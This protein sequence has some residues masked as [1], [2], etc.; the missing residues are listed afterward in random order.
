MQ[1][2]TKLYL[3]AFANTLV[4]A[5]GIITSVV[6]VYVLSHTLTINEFGMWAW[7]LSVCTIV[8]AQDFGVISAMR[9]EIGKQIAS[10]NIQ[11]QDQLLITTF[12]GVFFILC[13]AVLILGFLFFNIEKLPALQAPY[14]LFS[15][16]V[17]IALFS[18]FGTVSAN[19]LL[20][21][22]KEE[23]VAKLDFSRNILQLS[24]VGVIFFL[25]LSF[26][27][28][29]LAYFLPYAIY[30]LVGI[31]FVLEARTWSLA[32]FFRQLAAN[33]SDVIQDFTSLF[34]E[35]IPLWVMQLS[36]ILFVGSELVYVGFFADQATI[37]TTAILQRYINIAIGFTAASIMPFV[38]HYAAK[39]HSSS[40]EDLAWLQSKSSL[41]LK[42]I[43]SVGCLYT[44]ILVL[45]GSKITYLW[46]G[47]SLEAPL[48]FLLVGM[49]F[50]VTGMNSLFQLFYQSK[51]VYVPVIIAQLS[52]SL[53]KLAGIALLFNVLAMMGIWISFLIANTIFLLF[54]F[55]YI[56]R[57][58]LN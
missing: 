52:C 18:L 45:F 29:V 17:L 7:L 8:T 14:S 5:L 20:A 30:A 2:D 13:V 4:K 49:M 51:K 58:I 57:R 28:A 39:I 16:V 33:L 1:K 25:Q 37:G 31:Y 41:K 44:L 47:Q 40:K 24:A 22:L 27:W 12:F 9:I 36:S 46:S 35:G 3:V 32:E 6:A 53:I 21:F 55:F 11:R 34:K 48:L 10:Q 42:I 50:T 19:A 38:G 23:A 15:I 54:N 26:E 56:R 43:A